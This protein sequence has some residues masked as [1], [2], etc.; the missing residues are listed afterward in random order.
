MYAKSKA[1]FKRNRLSDSPM[2][3]K[4]QCALEMQVQ[5]DRSRLLFLDGEE[6]STYEFQVFFSFFTVA[7]RRSSHLRMS[8]AAYVKIPPDHLSQEFFPSE[9]ANNGVTGIL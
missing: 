1:I 3:L 2:M 7:K 8:N 9:K 6:N 5:T 4:I